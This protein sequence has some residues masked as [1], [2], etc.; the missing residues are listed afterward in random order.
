M[1]FYCFDISRP[2]LNH[3]LVTAVESRPPTIPEGVSQA[4]TY[5]R[6]PMQLT[7]LIN[8]L[9][10][11]PREFDLFS[12]T[13]AG[14]DFPL[15]L[16]VL[17][18]LCQGRG[19]RQGEDYYSVWNSI[20]PLVVKAAARVGMLDLMSGKRFDTPLMKAY[21]NGSWLIVQYLLQMRARDS[22]LGVINPPIRLVCSY[23]VS[24]P[25]GFVGDG[26][27]AGPAAI[28]MKL[29]PHPTSHPAALT[30]S[31]APAGNID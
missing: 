7:E 8:L 5:A 3:F 20:C 9:Q 31:V 15:G 11:R 22:H 28:L 24:L 23:L 10:R 13:A 18:A 16:G 6:T 4:F 12:V 30:K 17:D 29:V 21:A 2:H 25:K 19:V 14:D 27:G 26:W 1:I